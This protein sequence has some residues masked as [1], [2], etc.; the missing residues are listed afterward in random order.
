MCHNDSFQKAK[1]MDAATHPSPRGKQ[2]TP[3]D[4]RSKRKELAGQGAAWDLYEAIRREPCEEMDWDLEFDQLYAAL[5]HAA[6]SDTDRFSEELLRHL[7]AAGSYFVLRAEFLIG[8]VLKSADRRGRRSGPYLP[9]SLVEDHLP[10]L[11]DLYKSVA[12]IASLRASTLRQLELTRAKRSVNSERGQQTTPGPTKP[13]PKN[14]SS[15]IERPNGTPPGANGNGHAAK[16]IH[17]P[18][19]RLKDW[20]N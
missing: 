8:Q 15:P 12:E 1:P 2:E 6:A 5:Q 20:P 9:V 10:H 7:L 19:N 13:L 14:G 17:R 4:P 11:F 3:Q 18:I 16:P